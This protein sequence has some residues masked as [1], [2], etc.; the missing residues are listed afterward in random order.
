MSLTL[1]LSGTRSVLSVNYF[2]P[3]D[4][5][6][7]AYELGL[8]NFETYNTIPNVTSANNKFYFG[9]KDTRIRIPDGSY[10][11]RDIDAYLRAAIRNKQRKQISIENIDIKGDN[12]GGDDLEDDDDYYGNDDYVFDRDVS[13]SNNDDVDEDERSVIIR[14]NYNTMKSEIKCAYRVNF[15]KP[16][17]IGALLGFSPTRILEPN[18]WYASD[19]PINITSVNII[20]VECNITTGAY[21]NE[22]PVHTIHEFAIDVPPGYKL[23]QTPRQIIYLPVVAQNV[24][25]LTLRV[26]DQVGLPIDF[27][28]EEI[29]IR[30]HIRR[31]H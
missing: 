24:T 6:D 12:D 30:L 9:D 4:L 5:S 25:E 10:E 23:S 8:A 7:G 3:I 21:S 19:V 31:K 1:T 20:R 18:K 2:P 15:T 27:R 29:T 28:G 13:H 26:V 11:L 16:Y 22:R 14:G 17:N